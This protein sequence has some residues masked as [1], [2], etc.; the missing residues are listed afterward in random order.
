MHDLHDI[1]KTPQM[2]RVLLCEII[3]LRET[4]DDPFVQICY[5][6]LI[7]ND[8]SNYFARISSALP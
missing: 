4:L 3:I 1:L 6:I 7:M 8:I 2:Y 5:R